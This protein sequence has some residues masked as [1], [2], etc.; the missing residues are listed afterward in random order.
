MNEQNINNNYNRPGNNDVVEIDLADLFLYILRHWRSLI[1]VMLIVGVLMGGFKFE[2]GLRS[3]TDSSVTEAADEQKISRESYESKKSLLEANISNITKQLDEAKDYLDKSILMKIDKNQ[4][5]RAHVTYYISTDGEDVK[6]EKEV[7]SSSDIAS[8]PGVLVIGNVDSAVSRQSGRILTAYAKGIQ[9]NGVISQVKESYGKKVSGK[10]LRELMHLTVDYSTGMLD[11]S[12]V[13]DSKE[14][15]H[16]FAETVKYQVAANTTFISKNIGSHSITTLSD[17]EYITA[18][19]NYTSSNQDQTGS[20]YEA[21]VA[22]IQ[23][24][25]TGTITDLQNRLSDANIQLSTLEEPAAPTAVTKRDALKSGIKF[26]VI[27]LLLGLV[28]YAMCL[29]LYYVASG[30]IIDTDQITGRKRLRVLGHFYKPAKKGFGHAFDRFLAKLEHHD[31]VEEDLDSVMKGVVINTAVNAGESDT[32]LVIGGTKDLRD[33]FTD[34]AEG[35]FKVV[36][37]ENI[38]DCVE[39][40]EALGSADGVVML[41]CRNVTYRKDIDTTL[42]QAKAYGKPFLGIAIF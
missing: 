25:F 13:G 31:P 10:Y 30:R 26:G 34:T 3:L 28:V 6:N 22:S 2:K 35:R 4:V 17:S 8:S 36:E 37:A 21:N 15:V 16:A 1:L 29:T 11:I 9:G 20:L 18:D 42:S 32:V 24:N 27:G 19:S 39:G 14:L 7:A 5:Y 41:V 40:M 33:K 23:Q 38:H 12:I